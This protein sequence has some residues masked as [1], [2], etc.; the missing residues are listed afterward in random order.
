VVAS[1]VVRTQAAV[2]GMAHF[3]VLALPPHTMRPQRLVVEN[4]AGDEETRTPPQQ[5]RGQSA[6]GAATSYEP[7]AAHATWKQ[8]ARSSGGW[9]DGG[10]AGAGEGSAAGRGEGEGVHDADAACGSGP[11]LQR[12]LSPTSPMAALLSPS[13][14]RTPLETKQNS[15]EKQVRVPRNRCQRE[16]CAHYVR[17]E[18]ST[19]PVQCCHATMGGI[20]VDLSGCVLAQCLPLTRLL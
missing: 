5:S 12:L 17:D 3:H 9:V 14:R 13:R 10:A 1:N 16:R 20:H 4:A 6:S 2:E 19:T 11:L 8:R 18:R 15:E 7:D